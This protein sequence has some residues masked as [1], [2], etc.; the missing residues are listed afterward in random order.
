MIS[1]IQRYFQHHFRIIFGVM[2]LIMVLPLIWVFNPSS[3]LGR[4]ERRVIDRPFFG[5]NLN[6]QEDQQRLMGDA[7]LSANLQLG[8]FGGLDS[9]QIQNYAFQRAASLYLADE[10]HIP[11]SSPAE[12]ADMI[13]TLRI[14]AG[15][16]GQFDPKAYATFRDNLRTSRN[17]ITE[18]DI[19]RVIAGDIRAKKVQDLLAGPGYVLPGDVKTQLARADTSW[20]LATATADYKSF[21]PSI[22]P[23]EADLAKYFEENSFRYEIPPRVVASYIDFPA[24]N[25]L[26]AVTVTDAE[27]RAD[28]DANPTRFPKPATDA[29]TP[30]PAKPNPDADFAAVR[31]QVETA[32]RLER[33]QRLA[34]KAASDAALALYEG[35]ITP[36]AALDSF[37]VTHKLALKSLAP[38]THEAG[39]AE[40]GGS[41]DIATEAF[42]LGPDSGRFISEALSSPTGAVILV[43]K[44]LQATRKPPLTEVHDKV[45]ADYAENEKRKRFV[46]LGKT[47]KAQIESRL[48][49]GDAFDKAVAAAAGTSGI[50]I[51]AKTLAAFT[52]RNRP[53]D[54]DYSLLGSLDRLAKGELSDMNIAADKGVFVYA[55]DKQTPDLSESNPQFV[56]TRNQLASYASRLGGNAYLAEL[57]ETELKKSEP[58]ME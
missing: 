6:L 48:K 19:A 57:V 36:G 22:A 42:K 11:A 16:D 31:P 35:K 45:A 4:A 1:W 5:Y 50:K 51:E 41:Q 26:P 40:L 14:F 54:V 56:T 10:W 37:L 58:K 47:I 30:A 12:I 43:W 25:Y 23:S 27:V 44:E 17:G 32:L 38:F 7:G 46:E 24:L 49:A 20:T 29:K 39:P 53:S 9:D 13:K 8:S 3:G 34:V 52:L 18:A 21:N 28:Y 33:A 2:L 55:V 15:Q